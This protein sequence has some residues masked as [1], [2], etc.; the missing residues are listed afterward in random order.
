M[1]RLLL[2]ALSIGLLNSAYAV[3]VESIYKAQVPVA[4][5]SD[6][7]KKQ[8]L[9]KA[10]AQ[11]LIKVSGKSNVL[12]NP[13]LK[14]QLKNATDL[15]QEFGYT[16]VD[17]KTQLTTRFDADNINQILR[18]AGVP[19]W[20]VNRPLILAWVEFEVPNQPAEIIGSEA[21]SDIAALLTQHASERGL[22]ILLPVLDMADM[23]QVAVNDIV[24]MKIPSLL[25]AAKRYSSDAILVTRVF[26]NT[27]GFS[28]Q[29]KLVLGSDTW[30]W[31]LTGKTKADVL[32]QLIDNVTD[33]LAGKYST[34][35]SNAV[36]TNLTVKI[37]GI[38][39]QTDLA[40]I[41]RYI[42]HIAAV[43]D[44]QPVKISGNEVVLNV[45]LRGTKQAFVE[46]V[47]LDKKLTLTTDGSTLVYQWN[48]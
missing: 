5:Q 8:G 17:A 31:N 23:N 12:D 37:T 24:T 6:Q 32:S 44:V 10:L 48:H 36:Q 30:D 40:E 22:P 18:E 47:T 41:T 4:S 29:A 14:S 7:D 20:G 1:K 2:L 45:S 3:R 25:D 42:Q 39:Q 46:A 13:A 34:V 28:V 19:I 16:V 11:V 27:D 43:A 26:Q 9:Q 21:G 33:T 35:V 15:A 38:T